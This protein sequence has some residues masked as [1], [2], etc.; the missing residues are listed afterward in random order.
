MLR[1]NSWVRLL[2]IGSMVTLFTMRDYV[3][4]RLFLALWACYM[5]MLLGRLIMGLC[6]AILKMS[7]SKYPPESQR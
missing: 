4:A 1:V 6:C 2:L 5:F 7:L 3:S